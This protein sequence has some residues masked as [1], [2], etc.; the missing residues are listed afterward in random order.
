MATATTSTFLDYLVAN[1]SDHE[2]F[3]FSTPDEAYE[4]GT[5]LRMNIEAE[6]AHSGVCNLEVSISNTVVR[7]RAKS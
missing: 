6:N 4:F 1:G 7:V 5:R 3:D 2:R